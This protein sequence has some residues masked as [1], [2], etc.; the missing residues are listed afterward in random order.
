MAEPVP[1]VIVRI[2]REGFT[3]TIATNEAG[4]F[5][6]EGRGAG[7]YNVS[8]DVPDGYY[9]DVPSTVVDLRDARGCADASATLYRTA[10]SRDAS[11][12]PP[13]APCPG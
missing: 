5:E 1:G 12:M 2:S 10:S 3:D 6:V 11:S 7:A 13:D 8:V 4:D 9:A